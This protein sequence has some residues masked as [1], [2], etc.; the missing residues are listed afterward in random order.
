MS[1]NDAISAFLKSNLLFM[2]YRLKFLGCLERFE[3][4]E[5]GSKQNN[6][7]Q[8]QFTKSLNIRAILGKSLL[9]LN[10]MERTSMITSESK[11][12]NPEFC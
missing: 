11:V 8:F 9:N 2:I 5:N 7:N 6:S 10:N 3:K 12:R 4:T 1:G